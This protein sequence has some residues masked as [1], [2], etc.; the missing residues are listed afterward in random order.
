[1]LIMTTK[2]P[3]KIF[4]SVDDAVAAIALMGFEDGETRVSI[5]PKGSGRCFVEVLDIDD[6]TV[7]GRI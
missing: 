3:H 2:K 4:N 5:D 6:G 1:M 7:I